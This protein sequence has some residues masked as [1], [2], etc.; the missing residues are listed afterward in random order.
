MGILKFNFYP[1]QLADERPEMSSAYITGPDRMPT[2]TR[3]ELRP[4]EL[5]CIRKPN[6][7]GCLSIPWRV[8]SF[9][10]LTL[11]T[12]T[13]MERAEPYQ[14][15]VELARGKLNQVRN[16]AADWDLAGFALPDCERLLREAESHFARAVTRQQAPPEAVAAAHESLLKSL[17][18][19][20]LLTRFCT[21]KLFEIRHRQHARLPVQLGCALGTAPVPAGLAT[22]FLEAFNLAVLPFP[23]REVEPTEGEYVWEPADRQ[24][25]WCL[26]RGLA[27]RGGPLVRFSEDS[28]PDWLWLWEADLPNL[29]SFVSDII[30]TTVARYRGRVASWEITGSTNLAER[31][32][33]SDEDALRLTLQA[34]SA[35]RQIDPDARCLVGIEQPW[36]EYLSRGKQSLSPLHFADALLRAEPEIAGLNLEVAFGYPARGSQARDLMEW[37]RLLDLYAQLA[38]PLHVTLGAPSGWQPDPNASVAADDGTGWWHK[39]WDLQAQAECAAEFAGVAI[40]K[41]YVQAVTWVHFLDGAPHSLANAG[42]VGLDGQA[43]PALA[44]LAELRQEHLR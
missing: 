18:A 43:K 26:S 14:L 6:E 15:Q 24:L 36:G 38:V 10:W 41:P 20:E 23:W 13:L 28:I 29:L 37:S 4:G 32:A 33:M 22:S 1:P 2:A 42:L 35:A 39:R 11:T 19:A 31:L 44:R 27:V 40:S 21:E 9:G 12:A 3:T 5:T 25:Q 30:E 34:V 16:Q 7:S 17:E 8:D